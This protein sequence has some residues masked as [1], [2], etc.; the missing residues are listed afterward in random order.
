MTPVGA[1]RRGDRVGRPRRTQVQWVELYTHQSLYVLLWFFQASLLL[2]LASRSPQDR[3]ALVVVGLVAVLLAL[4]AMP[5][6]RAVVRLYPARGPVPWR[7]LGPLLVG[8][9]VALAGVPLLPDDLRA[10]APLLVWLPLVWSLSGLRSATWTVVVV[11]CAAGVPAVGGEPASVVLGLLAGVFVLFSVRVSLWLEDVVRQLDRARGTRA[12]LAVAEERLRFSRDVHDVLGRRL[13][14]IAVQSEL[15]AALASRGDERAAAQMLDVRRV[16]HESLREAR[17]LARG[18]RTS[19]LASELEGAR[20][21]LRSADVALRAD[22]DDLPPDRREAA[23]RG[24]R[25]AVTNVLRHSSA[26]TVDVSWDTA[27]LVVRND[28]ASVGAEGTLA[29]DSPGQGAG[30]VGLRERLRP[31]GGELT[32]RR[33]GDVF[34]LRAELGAATVVP[35]E[36]SR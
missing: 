18:Y 36:V 21:L 35:A 6:L 15:A 17:D 33:D 16:A 34:V 8:S 29:L 5:V 2:Q 30:L 9:A 24:G 19:D 14:T 28:G 31:L 22:L 10:V 7:R 23:A 12:A 27:S 3:D 1:R 25:E 11:A 26:T 20:S 13:A 4:A 32:A